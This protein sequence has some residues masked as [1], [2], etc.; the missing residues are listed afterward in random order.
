[1]NHLDVIKSPER[2]E[3]IQKRTQDENPISDGI[4][5][6]HC[7]CLETYKNSKDPNN[8]DLWYFVIGA[9]KVD[10]YSHCHNCDNWFGL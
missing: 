9:F 2:K 1:M 3:Q 8:T 10:E 7:G 6:P 4:R 5:C